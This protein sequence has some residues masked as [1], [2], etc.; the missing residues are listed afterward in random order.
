MSLTTSESITHPMKKI[1]ISK[2]VIN[3]GVGKAGEPLE[4]VKRG[5]EELTGQQPTTKGAKKSVRDFGI[6]KGEPIAAVVTLR[7][8]SA[9]NFLRRIIA[10][11]G[12]S[13]K[14]SSF[15][16]YGNL[17][18]GIREHIDLPDTKYNP[19]IG[20]FGMDVSVALARPGYSVAKK[21]NPKVVGQH[22]RV[23][24]AEAFQFFEEHFGVKI[25]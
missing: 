16:N 17:S 11:K 7:H 19:D 5:L 3:I 21:R 20:I 12:N 22:H 24:K 25:V 2:V 9:I 18:V 8:G 14:A 4:R 15:D 13:I 10:A 23:T 6:H 1:G